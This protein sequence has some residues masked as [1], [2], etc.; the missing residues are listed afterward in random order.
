[1]ASFF[2]PSDSVNVVIGK[3]KLAE[4]NFD[5]FGHYWTTKGD[6]CC[7]IFSFPRKGW[8]N[9]V[10]LLY[11]L[12]LGSVWGNLHIYKCLQAYES[13]QGVTIATL[14]PDVPKITLKAP[15]CVHL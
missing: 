7:F 11:I 14:W 2:C 1:M 3:E 5:I 12:I 4:S 13:W 10:L 15:G 8:Q 6:T 9:A